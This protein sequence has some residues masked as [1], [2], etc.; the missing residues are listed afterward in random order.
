MDQGNADPASKRALQ[1]YLI[2]ILVLWAIALSVL[3]LRSKV[4]SLSPRYHSLLPIE[5]PYTD[6]IRYYE[7]CSSFAA[8]EIFD[9]GVWPAWIYPAP[10]AYLQCFWLL[11]STHAVRILFGITFCVFFGAAWLLWLQVRNATGYR[12]LA[13]IVIAV[14]LLTSFPLMVLLNRANMEPVVTALV[15]LFLLCFIRTR[16]WL[17]ALFLVIACCIKPYSGIFFLLM[18]FRKRF[19]ETAVAVCVIAVANFL[20]LA[21]MNPS[22]MAA[23]RGIQAGQRLFL[24]MDVFTMREFQMSFDHSLFSC[25]QQVVRFLAG[26]P[27]YDSRTLKLLFV[28]YTAL[29]M[30]GAGVVII[31]AY[32]MPVLNQFFAFTILTVL[33]PWFSFDYTLIELYLPWGLLL[34]YLIQPPS[35]GYPRLGLAELLLILIPCAVIFTPQTYLRIGEENGLGGQVKAVALLVLLVAILWRPMPLRIFSSDWKSGG[36]ELPA[37]RNEIE[38]RKT[39]D[40]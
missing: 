7:K 31:R 37:A 13:A 15:L 17:A 21:G 33:L 26:H 23:Y 18:L 9:G 40:A 29:S 14:T 28:P 8:G 10:A 19:V 1:I 25:L 38:A 34:M 11:H 20:A 22:P 12:V 27:L 32:R 6:L 24:A 2:A 5:E 30:A 39:A 35:D 36:R 4:D 16:Y 3:L